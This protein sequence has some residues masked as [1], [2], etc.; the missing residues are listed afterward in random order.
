MAPAQ[1]EDTPG[2]NITKKVQFKLP[3]HV[4]I[5]QEAKGWLPL[6][7]RIVYSWSWRGGSKVRWGAE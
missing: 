5:L 6:T 3:I 7:D 2:F 4:D 1:L